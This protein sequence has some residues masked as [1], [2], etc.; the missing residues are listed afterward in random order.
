MKES[1][2]LINSTE[3]DHNDQQ[4]DISMYLKALWSNK[5]KILS[6]TLG[7]AIIA[8][9][10]ILRMPSI[11]EASATLFITKDDTTPVTLSDGFSMDMR[12]R[13]YLKTQFSI[14]QSESLAQ[15]VIDS[16]DLLDLEK[17]RENENNEFE[18]WNE[19]KKFLGAKNSEKKY[20]EIDKTELK[21]QGVLNWYKKNLIVA[22]VSN[23]QLVRLSFQSEDPQLAA[24]IVNKLGDSYINSFLDAKMTQTDKAI[25]WLQKRSLQVNTELAE[26]ENALQNFV[27]K[28]Q[29]VNLQSGIQTLNEET[30]KNI[31]DR[32][33]EVKNERIQ[34]E[35][36]ISYTNSSE[37]LDEGLISQLGDSPAIQQLNETEL[38]SER[39]FLEISQRY[40]PKHPKYI[41]SIKELQQ[42]R[43]KLAIQVKKEMAELSQKLKNVKQTEVSLEL[44]LKNA[45]GQ[46]LR[47]GSKES[48]F[49]KLKTNV[50][51]LTELRD[52]ISKRF[53]ELDI[54]SDFNSENARFV[55]KAKRPL[56]P[57]KPRK[58][59]ILTLVILISSGLASLIVII[60]TFLN[61]SFRKTAEI[62]EHLNAKF[63]GIL[64]K[65]KLKKIPLHIY[66][67]SEFRLFS[68]SIKT[69]RT[70]LILNNLDR[71]TSINLVT[72]A[73]P[74]EGKSTTSLNMAFS[75]AQMEKVLLIDADLRKPTVAKRFG[76][77]SYQR[78]LSDILNKNISIEECIITDE[79][80][81]IDL[82][83]AGQYTTNSLELFSNSNFEDVLVKLK[84][85]Y[86]RIIIDSAPCQAVSDTLVLA[87]FA[88]ATIFVVKADS[89]KKQIVKRAVGRLRDVGA[90]IEGVVLNAA[91]I[92]KNSEEYGG[93]YDY[94]GYSQKS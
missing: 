62:E 7:V 21:N 41:A 4:I 18:F 19:T 43:E 34:L 87:R 81:G 23:T 11:Y 55:D 50:Q 66:F 79:K 3:T 14:L 44:E 60:I 59:L 69:I 53:K 26:A 27:N 92:N 30:L 89:T 80:S 90:S 16:L 37:V 48:E 6:F 15:D 5:W 1:N 63:L 33:L 40:G 36:I 28:E 49:R 9:M 17:F 12:A 25:E 67:D 71:E 77:P 35:N 32:L 39:K 54:T 94:Y 38:N 76:F 13:E 22:P 75:F 31:N 2:P 91:D 72:S 52:L 84:D 70:G 51:R 20:G 57:V 74:G 82:L 73:V 24:D 29:I 93:Y 47:D 88:D 42:V 61:D 10:L 85:K 68:E 46:F 64:P 78:G 86:D 65:L 8:T 58:G 83:P 56:V 45:E